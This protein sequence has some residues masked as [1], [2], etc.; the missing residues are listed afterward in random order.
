MYWFGGLKDKRKSLGPETY[1]ILENQYQTWYEM[2]IFYINTHVLQLSNVHH[3]QE[4]INNC[5]YKYSI[6]KKYFVLC[7]FCTQN[8]V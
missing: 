4:V 8:R 5:K 1:S 6:L 2:L 3:G 7:N